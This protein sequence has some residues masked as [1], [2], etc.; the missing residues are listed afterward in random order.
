MYMRDPPAPLFDQTK[1]KKIRPR[2]FRTPY[3]Q[4]SCISVCRD[5]S[6]VVHVQP[7]RLGATDAALLRGGGAFET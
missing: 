3:V 2:V 4:V 7:L 5:I 1:N 6:D